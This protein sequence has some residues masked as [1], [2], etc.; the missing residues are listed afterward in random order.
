MSCG[1]GMVPDKKNRFL[2]SGRRIRL[3]SNENSLLCFIGGK[4]K[5]G[6]IL[7]RGCRKLKF[8]DFFLKVQQNF[9]A[10]WL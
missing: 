9:V 1:G 7:C 6:E 3:F 10:T 2:W 5:R 8:G 4:F